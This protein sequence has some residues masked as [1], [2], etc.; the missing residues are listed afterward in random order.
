MKSNCKLPIPFLKCQRIDVF[1]CHCQVSPITMSS[2]EQWCKI[3]FLNKIYASTTFYLGTKKKGNIRDGYIWC[4]S[5]SILMAFIVAFLVDVSYPTAKI[6]IYMTNFSPFPKSFR[7][8]GGW[9]L[10]ST[11]LCARR[12]Q[13][14]SASSSSPAGAEESSK[15]SGERRPKQWLCPGGKDPFVQG[16]VAPPSR[17]SEM[18]SR[19]ERTAEGMLRACCRGR[20]AP[21]VILWLSGIWSCNGAGV[22]S[23]LVLQQHPASA[24]DTTI[25]SGDYVWG[26]RK[27]KRNHFS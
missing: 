4:I 23:L 15:G 19:E 5:L 16:F 2:L 14:A 1:Q 13:T 25:S 22:K 24:T 3:C 8:A 6:Q 21:V 17:E 27:R 11:A 9:Q 12:K 18:L 26:E 10:A 20:R 7:Q